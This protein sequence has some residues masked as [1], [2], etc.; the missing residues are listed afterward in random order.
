M[1]EHTRRAVLA[2]AAALAA[3][4]ASAAP[5]PV[6]PGA[7][8]AWAFEFPAIEGGTLRL[9]EFRGRVLL[10]VNTASFCGYTPQYRALE[11]LHER[12]SPRG[13]VVVGVPSG[14]F[15]QEK[16]TDGEVKAFCEATFGVQFPMAAISAVRGPDAAPFYRW[17]REERRWQP[18]WNFAKVLVGRDGRIAGT[19]APSAE[20][21][22]DPVLAAITA[23]L[24]Q[25]TP[26]AG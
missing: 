14:D 11:A 23:A 4:P 20:P 2:G 6:K 10:V 13:L 9:A 16:A 18:G 26:A 7:R 1:A 22:R 15:G 3:A 12:L 8:T 24:A 17:V 21:D 25:P 19:Y 5:E